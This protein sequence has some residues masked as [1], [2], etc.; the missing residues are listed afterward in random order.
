MPLDDREQQILAELEKSL[1]EEHPDLARVV[2]K[3]EKAGSRKLRLGIAGVVVGMIIVLVSFTSQ[4]LVA[5]AGFAVIVVSATALVQALMAR[6]RAA[7]GGG[8]AP[9]GPRRDWGNPFRRGS[10]SPD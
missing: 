9:N 10:G 5:L 8:P 4:T 2:G 6:N 7:G 3:I 1:Y